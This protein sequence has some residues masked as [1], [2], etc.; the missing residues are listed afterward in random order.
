MFNK[1]VTLLK[2]NQKVVSI[3]VP[4]V[5]IVVIA[6]GLLMMRQRMSESF[7]AGAGMGKKEL[8][9]FSMP[10]CS[11]CEALQPVWD[12]FYSNMNNSHQ[13]A[14]IQIKSNERP[15]MVEKYGV[16]TFPTILYL[17]DGKMA[18]KYS[19]DRSYED[20]KRYYSY[21]MSDH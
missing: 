15:E 19:G 5:V 1:L 4:V 14:L 17:K 6:L 2:K 8:V 21:V 11:H 18:D 20:L 13:V 12:N 10:G 7:T 16:K 9:F 3:A